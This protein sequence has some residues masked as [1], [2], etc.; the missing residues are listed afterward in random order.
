MSKNCEYCGRA[1]GDSPE[2]DTARVEVDRAKVML[3]QNRS[4]TGEQR[5]TTFIAV[6]LSLVGALFLGFGVHSCERYSTASEQANSAPKVAAAQVEVAKADLERTKVQADARLKAEMAKAQAEA[7]AEKYKACLARSADPAL[8]S[9]KI[10]T[11]RCLPPLPVPA[12]K[13]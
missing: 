9:G 13:E 2:L 11:V 7:D 4:M 3:E 5:Q 6:G 1:Y 12:K 8:C 10:E